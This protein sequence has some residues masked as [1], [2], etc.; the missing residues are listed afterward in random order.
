MAR[1]WETFDSWNRI[2]N[3]IQLS[4]NDFIYVSGDALVIEILHEMVW[5]SQQTKGKL[6][7]KT[8][9]F[10]SISRALKKVVSS[11]D[12]HNIHRID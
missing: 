4:N 12:A 3:I 2:N 7:P 11:Q 9:N 5:I 1:R 10:I 6:Q 8:V